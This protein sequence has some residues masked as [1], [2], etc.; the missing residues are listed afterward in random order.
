[1]LLGRFRWVIAWLYFDVQLLT[2]WY[3][4]PEISTGVRKPSGKLPRFEYRR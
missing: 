3:R 2:D 4:S 1:M